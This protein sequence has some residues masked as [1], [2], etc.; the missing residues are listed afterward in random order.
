MCYDNEGMRAEKLSDFLKSKGFNATKSNCFDNFI[1]NEYRSFSRYNGDV[2][3]VFT[4][5]EDE[6]AVIEEIVVN[7]TFPDELHSTSSHNETVYRAVHMLD[8]DLRLKDAPKELIEKFSES[9]KVMLT[10]NY[11]EDQYTQVYEEYH[12]V[13]S[14]HIVVYRKEYVTYYTPEDPWG[15]DYQTKEFPPIVYSR[16]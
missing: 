15:S 2:N 1:F 11:W 4:L 6:K 16:G 7:G 5:S 14:Y 13:G 12:L 8:E 9:R 3:R 10:D